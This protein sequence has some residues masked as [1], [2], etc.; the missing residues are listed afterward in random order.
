LCT[1]FAIA[2]NQ[3]AKSEAG[4]I[5]YGTHRAAHKNLAEYNDKATMVVIDSGAYGVF[6]ILP[7]ETKGLPEHLD[8]KSFR[9]DEEAGIMVGKM[10]PGKK[11]LLSAQK[12][13]AKCMEQVWT[14]CGYGLAISR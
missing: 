4:Y 14:R 13:M 8:L 6:K 9:F 5:S 1:S 7:G 11:S 3:T 12:A 10:A 2:V